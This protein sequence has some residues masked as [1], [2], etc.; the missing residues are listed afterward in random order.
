MTGNLSN[1][2]FLHQQDNG[3]AVLLL[4]GLG[5]GVYEFS[6]LGQHLYQQG[7]TVCGINYPGHNQRSSKM[8]ASKWEDWYT[9]AEESYQALA[10]DHDHISIIGFS[11][12]CMLSLELIHNHPTAIESLT[13]LSPFMKVRHQWYFGATPETYVRVFGNYLHDVPR[14]SLP[15]SDRNMLKLAHETAY[16]R[17]FSIPSVKSALELIERVKPKL[18]EITT[19]TLIVQSPHDRVVCPTGAHQLME[20]LGSTEKELLWLEKSNHVVMLDVEREH[21]TKRITQFLEP[22][23]RRQ[24]PRIVKS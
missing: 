3:H 22:S 11:T 13:L 8:P 18:P 21:V 15:I 19:P 5:G 9:H 24:H 10:R 20:T 14:F 7:H 17:S 2:P 6:L 1:E 16:F 4:H 23:R 12:G